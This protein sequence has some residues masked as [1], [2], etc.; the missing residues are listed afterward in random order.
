[1]CCVA[2]HLFFPGGSSSKHVW[3]KTWP[4]SEREDDACAAP[5]RHTSFLPSFYSLL[6]DA[7]VLFRKYDGPLPRVRRS[8]RSS[9]Q[10]KTRTNKQHV[11]YTGPWP[12]APGPREYGIFQVRN[13]STRIDVEFD[14]TRALRPLV[15]V[16]QPQPVERTTTTT[17]RRR[18]RFPSSQSV[19]SVVPFQ[20][21]S[22]P[23][24]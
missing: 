12:L 24:H 23:H 19:F 4:G 13:H 21:F 18:R 15:S 22:T 20:L 1:M 3:P 6:S 5:A 14:G 9:Q 8:F 16:L 17:R 10:Q 2:S 11:T 7:S